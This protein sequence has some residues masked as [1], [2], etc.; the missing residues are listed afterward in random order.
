M[1]ID[2]TRIINFTWQVLH[3]TTCLWIPRK[4]LG[5]TLHIVTISLPYHS[6][7]SSPAWIKGHADLC[8][9]LVYSL[10]P[11]LEGI[12]WTG[13]C[14]Y[15]LTWG[16]LVVWYMPSCPEL[17]VSCG[18]VYAFMLWL[19]GILW[20]GLCL[21]ALTWG[22][23]VVWSMPSCPDLRVSCGLVYALT[24]GYFVACSMPLCPDLMA[25]SMSLCPDLIVW[26]GLF[27][28]FMPWR[29]GLI[30]IFMSWLDGPLWHDLCLHVLT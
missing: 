28:A 17:R 15:T 20:S 14:L 25:W 29:D 10:M 7:A 9:L 13:I 22:Y 23:I 11:W 24:W 12:L 4:R 8:T 30:Y 1:F 21:H 6:L 26:C 3:H 5:G 18:L 19:E 16:Y 2:P 27:Y